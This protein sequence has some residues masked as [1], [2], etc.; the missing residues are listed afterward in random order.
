MARKHIYTNNQH[1]YQSSEPTLSSPM[2]WD[3]ASAIHALSTTKFR[4]NNTLGT[5]CN[6]QSVML[7]IF[8][9]LSNMLNMDS[10]HVVF[11][12]AS[13][14]PSS[15]QINTAEA[16]SPW[17]SVFT[18]GWRV[19]TWEQP[20]LLT[21]HILTRMSR[22]LSD[23]YRVTVYKYIHRSHYKSTNVCMDGR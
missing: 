2:A 5:L 22:R 12:K 8:L 23:W 3:L 21:H 15:L 7:L 20:S 1:V 17:E 10:K 11:W 4:K 6:H 13:R 16:P 14:Q 19:E 18:A 9:V